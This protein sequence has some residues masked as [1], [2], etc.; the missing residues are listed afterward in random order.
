MSTKKETKPAVKIKD[1]KPVKSVKG[2]GAIKKTTGT[3]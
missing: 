1:L 2:G 3:H